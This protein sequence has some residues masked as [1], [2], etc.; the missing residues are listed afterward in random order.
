MTSFS[1]VGVYERFGG[2]HNTRLH[3]LYSED[4]GNAFL[5]NTGIHL[6]EYTTA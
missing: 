1:L 3:K 6:T 2:T 5:R 4:G